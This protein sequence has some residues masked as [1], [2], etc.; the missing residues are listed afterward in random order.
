VLN[1][2]GAINVPDSEATPEQQ[3]D[4]SVVQ[5]TEARLVDVLGQL[6]AM[7]IAATG[8]SHGWL[9]RL[10]TPAGRRDPM[11]LNWLVAGAAGTL[12]DRYFYAP[13]DREPDEGFAAFNARWDE[14]LD[15]A[16]TLAAELGLPAGGCS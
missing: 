15:E 9:N 3:R 1:Q 2:R 11:T 8:R 16:A 5:D 13:G 4:E 7:H 14:L 12:R 10:M 6:R